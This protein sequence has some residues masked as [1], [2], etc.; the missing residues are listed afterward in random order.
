MMQAVNIVYR[1]DK[2]A[3]RAFQTTNSSSCMVI[4]YMMVMY[5]RRNHHSDL[6]S[7]LYTLSNVLH[8]QARY[9]VL[10]PRHKT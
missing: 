9:G 4:T 1:D 3:K 6:L 10:R 2:I 5:N 8:T 7:L